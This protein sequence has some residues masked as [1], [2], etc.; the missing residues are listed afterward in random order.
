LLNLGIKDRLQRLSLV[1]ARTCFANHCASGIAQGVIVDFAI[2]DSTIV[3][4]KYPARSLLVTTG[5]STG[6][7]AGQALFNTF[8]IR[9]PVHWFLL[10]KRL[11]FCAVDYKLILDR[12]APPTEEPDGRIE[13]LLV[14]RPMTRGSKV[15]VWEAAVHINNREQGTLKFIKR[16][17]T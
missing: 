11:G 7:S 12:T 4:A 2:A 14:L 16:I 6:K 17:K 5:R 3:G 13:H 9:I 10:V 1:A 15:E 8:S